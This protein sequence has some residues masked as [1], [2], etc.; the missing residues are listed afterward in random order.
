[1]RQDK[2]SY[3]KYTNTC[4]YTFIHTHIYEK[5]RLKPETML[6]IEVFK[7]AAVAGRFGA[8]DEPH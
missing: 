4:T 1:M 5:K 2:A 6:R 7:S 8:F 3:T